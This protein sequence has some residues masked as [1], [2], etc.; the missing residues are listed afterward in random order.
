MK[1]HKYL[2]LTNLLICSL[3][4]LSC[5]SNKDTTALKPFSIEVIK[6]EEAIK[7]KCTTGCAWTELN[8]TKNNYQPQLVNQFG[9]SDAKDEL[10]KKTDD[11]LA[12]FAFSIS[13]TEEGIQLN[14]EQ[15]TAWKELNFSLKNYA[16]QVIT[17][18]GMAK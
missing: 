9:M 3:A 16:P 15:G 4:L 5:N 7:L 11:N 12:N 17:Q 13:K 2:I 8:F 6:T 10:S 18:I 1:S 14:G